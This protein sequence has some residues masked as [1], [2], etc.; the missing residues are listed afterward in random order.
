[1]LHSRDM[2]VESA[3][4]LLHIDKNEFDSI[5]KKLLQSELLQ[6][7]SFNVIELTEIGIDYLNKREKQNE[8]ISEKP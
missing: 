3:I 2:D 7:T 1:M 5:V 6:Y 8:N 4:N